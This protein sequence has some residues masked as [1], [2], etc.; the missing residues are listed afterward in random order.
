MLDT[1]SGRTGGMPLAAG[2]EVTETLRRSGESLDHITREGLR[3]YTDAMAAAMQSGMETS[4]MFADLG[5]SHMNAFVT[6]ATVAADIA[7]DSLLCRTPL[8]VAALQKRGFEAANAATES[9][10]KLCQDLYG[11]W[12]KAFQPVIARVADV[13][14]RMF[15]AIAD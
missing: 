11:A 4:R 12:S 14:E 9:S 3:C 5:G 2:D 13:P 10:I 6:S 1:A 15:Q 8:D 7:R